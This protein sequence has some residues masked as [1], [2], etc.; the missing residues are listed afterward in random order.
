[1]VNS[2]IVKKYFNWLDSWFKMVGED[3]IKFGA[4]RRYAARK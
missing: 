2:D 1:M 4:L 3:E